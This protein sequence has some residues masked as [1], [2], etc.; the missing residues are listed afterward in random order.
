VE[1]VLWATPFRRSGVAADNAGLLSFDNSGK[2][3][4]AVVPHW[5]SA[6]WASGGVQLTGLGGPLLPY[7]VLA[8]T[9]LA[10]PSWTAIGSATANAGGVLQFLQAS[11]TNSPERFYRLAR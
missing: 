10:A 2:G 8:C 11:V 1:S 6:Q 7:Q 3:L 4:N 5:V 9:N